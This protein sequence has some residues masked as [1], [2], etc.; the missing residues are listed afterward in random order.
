MN[1]IRLLTGISPKDFELAVLQAG[2][3]IKIQTKNGYTGII[4][5]LPKT[6]RIRKQY[7]NSIIKQDFQGR[8]FE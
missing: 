8:L 3:N 6:K 5:D 4:T 7:I 1:L 2:N